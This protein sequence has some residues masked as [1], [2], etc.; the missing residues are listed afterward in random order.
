MPARRFPPP[1]AVDPLLPHIVT[2]DLD[3][4]GRSE[5]CF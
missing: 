4:D 3:V 5:F 1:W 2:E